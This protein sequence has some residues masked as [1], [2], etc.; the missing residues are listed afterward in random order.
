MHNFLHNILILWQYPFP[1]FNNLRQD[2]PKQ[3]NIKKLHF[4]YDFFPEQG[5]Q[6]RNEMC[7]HH[8]QIQFW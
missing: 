2:F 4:G 7:A 1:F 6:I 3:I 8:I 5:V